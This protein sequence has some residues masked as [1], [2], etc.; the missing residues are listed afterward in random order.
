MND[1][2]RRE[3]AIFDEVLSLPPKERRA[4]LDRSRGA[5]LALRQRIE[6]LL[7]SHDNT[8]GILERAGLD[9]PLRALSERNIPGAHKVLSE[10]LQN[11]V[12]LYEA[13]FREDQ[14]SK[15]KQKLTESKPDSNPSSVK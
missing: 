10:A 15:W 11:P 14:A 9:Q 1:Q 3:G 2:L 5:D 6:A 7:A 13:T 12:Q 4:Y 8:H